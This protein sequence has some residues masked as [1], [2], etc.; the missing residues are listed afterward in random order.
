LEL[1]F[2]RT[3]RFSYEKKLI[4]SRSKFKM[5]KKRICDINNFYLLEEW[6]KPLWG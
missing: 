3:P 1:S 6:R 5:D 2:I 4:V